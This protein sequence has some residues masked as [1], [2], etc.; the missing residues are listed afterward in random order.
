MT[1]GQFL[2]DAS[3][4]LHDAQQRAPN[5][6]QD[7]YSVAAA[8]TARDFLYQ[9]LSKFL[10][11]IG[12][13]EPH[14]RPTIEQAMALFT[15][16]SN[17][18]RGVALMTALKAAT[19][20]LPV[21]SLALLSAPGTVAEALARS[22]FAIALATEILYTHY[23]PGPP[24]ISA[25]ARPMTPQGIALY[26]GAQRDEVVGE[27]A[28]LAA[29]GAA[30]DQSLVRLRHSAPQAL[31]AHD[32][33]TL[34]AS[35][36][37]DFAAQ[38]RRIGDLPLATLLRSLQPA[39]P[40]E[41]VA[42]PR[43]VHSWYDVLSTVDTA[44][45]A[46]VRN[47]N[48][49]TLALAGSVIRLG[50]AAA[51]TVWRFSAAAHPDQ[52][53]QNALQHWHAA[54]QQLAKHADLRDGIASSLATELQLASQWVRKQTTSSGHTIAHSDVANLA[55]LQTRLGSLCQELIPRLRD[56]ARHGDLLTLRGH[57]I[58]RTP[59]RGIQLLTAVPNWTTVR[60]IPALE[61]RLRHAAQRAITVAGRQ[62]DYGG[63][64]AA[65][66][67]LGNEHG[68]AHAVTAAFPTS[69][70]PSADRSR[71]QLREDDHPARPAIGGKTATVVEPSAVPQELR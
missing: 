4:A 52:A 56:A 68:H 24:N 14:S 62:L 46:L 51:A 5:M 65:P 41:H 44:R 28:R 29:A 49:A 2:D 54:G 42:G 57:T 30:I 3:R 11:A 71:G 15:E 6:G 59:R 34:L 1:V 20:D 45:S 39:P 40:I 50:I 43:P 10:I 69:F 61:Q 55:D 64:I 13:R 32:W 58:A 17:V 31:P 7:A 47:P 21:P 26:R 53:T 8:I 35:V 19:F 23:S 48:L 36:T 38:L 70:R 16:Q 37:H 25:S 67:Q 60:H 22:G 66:A 63:R 18:D 12:M 33:E 9:Q 27:A